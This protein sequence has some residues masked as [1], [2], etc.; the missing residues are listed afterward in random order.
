MNKLEPYRQA[1]RGLCELDAVR[2][3][4]EHVK[5]GLLVFMGPSLPHSGEAAS[6]SR[7]GHS[8]SQP[9]S[10]SW[11]G[12]LFMSRLH[13]WEALAVLTTLGTDHS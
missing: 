5:C 13:G 7:L 9:P 10:P 8:D 4:Q 11:N 6:S 3:L 2:G 12:V 1:A